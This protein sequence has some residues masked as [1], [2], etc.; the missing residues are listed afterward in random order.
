MD[1]GR[2]PELVAADLEVGE[3]REDRGVDSLAYLELDRLVGATGASAESFCTAC[4]SGEY[5]VPVPDAD[6]KLALEEEKV[7]APEAAREAPA[8]VEP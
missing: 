6:T 7:R 5:P 4:L 1:T 8:R 3:I 2:R